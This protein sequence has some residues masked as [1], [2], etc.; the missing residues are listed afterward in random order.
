MEA[1]EKLMGEHPEV[2]ILKRRLEA[3]H[4]LMGMAV[5]PEEVALK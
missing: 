2:V 3:V 1:L 5:K 4:G